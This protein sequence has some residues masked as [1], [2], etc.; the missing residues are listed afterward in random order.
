MNAGA[1]TYIIISQVLQVP[2]IRVYNK[3]IK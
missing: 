3:N 2:I 1:K